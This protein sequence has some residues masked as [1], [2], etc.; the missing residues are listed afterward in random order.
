MTLSFEKIRNE[1]E[2]LLINELPRQIDV[3]NRVHND[4]VVLVPFTNRTMHD[5]HLTPPYWKLTATS[6]ERQDKDILLQNVVWTVKLELILPH[7]WKNKE[8]LMDRY[9]EAITQ[10]LENADTEAWERI[11]VSGIRGTQLTARIVK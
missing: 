3:V 8:L 7:M 4:G 1:L 5:E 2:N 11:E 9:V 10:T 6:G